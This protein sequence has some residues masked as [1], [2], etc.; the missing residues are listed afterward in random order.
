MASRA[1][2]YRHPIHPMLVVFPIGLWVFSFVCDLVALKR[3]ENSVFWNDMAFYTMAGGVV[4][5]LLAAIPGY[6][7]FHSL[8]EPRVKRIATTH[9]VLN[10]IVIIL[11]VFNLG[12]RLNQ[13]VETKTSAVLI[14]AIAI[15]LLAISGWLGGSM[16][17]VH[18]V[19]VER[20]S[21]E[22]DR[23]DRAA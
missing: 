6:L 2:I 11:Y 8:R 3:P 5:A 15:F 16:V 13:P 10:V 14:S 1:S 18:G 20:A 23:R 12:F 17:Y 7:D 21:T 19:A 9:F 4:G 22:W